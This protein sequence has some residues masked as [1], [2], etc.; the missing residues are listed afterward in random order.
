ML[1]CL[2]TVC[3]DMRKYIFELLGAFK[4]GNQTK[5]TSVQLYLQISPYASWEHLAG[6]LFRFDRTTELEKSNRKIKPI[7]G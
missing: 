5:E 3:E 1:S 4:P 2:E 7:R 6:Q